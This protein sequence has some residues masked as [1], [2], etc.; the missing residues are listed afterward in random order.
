MNDLIAA[1]RHDFREK[2]IWV[3]GLRSDNIKTK[4][5]RLIK[6]SP[7]WLYTLKLISKYSFKSD[8]LNLYT[9]GLEIVFK[10]LLEV[11]PEIQVTDMF[12]FF[13]APT[14]SKRKC[15]MIIKKWDTEHREILEEIMRLKKKTSMKVERRMLE[16][17]PFYKIYKS[18]IID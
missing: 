17:N 3:P 11:L 7:K 8:D 18:F 15:Q 9:K 2:I 14:F 1:L 16:I 5:N 4:I 10:M 12:L 13:I 6:K